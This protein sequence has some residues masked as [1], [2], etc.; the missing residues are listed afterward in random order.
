MFQLQSKLT[1]GTGMS[2]IRLQYWV[3]TK[4]HCELGTVRVFKWYSKVKI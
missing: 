1:T 2:G 4:Q 3:C